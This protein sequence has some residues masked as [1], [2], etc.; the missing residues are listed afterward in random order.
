MADNSQNV[1][2]HQFKILLLGD[3][4]VG[5]TCF[6]LRF[7]ENYFNENPEKGDEISNV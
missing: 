1:P 2:T 4:A 6:F 3:S 5:K 7:T